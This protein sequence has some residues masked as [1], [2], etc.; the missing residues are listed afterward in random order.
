MSIRNR[1]DRIQTEL[2]VLRDWEE[3]GEASP[4]DLRRMR[5]LEKAIDELWDRMIHEQG[6]NSEETDDQERKSA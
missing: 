5:Y 3:R 2:Q 1:I 6:S 4:K